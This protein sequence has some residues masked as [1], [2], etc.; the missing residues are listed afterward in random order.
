MTEK[1]DTNPDD[2]SIFRQEMA[3]VQRLRHDRVHHRGSRPPPRPLQTL[4]EQREV[5]RDMMSDYHD[6]AE[7]ETGEELSFAR[8]GVPRNTLRRLRRGQF[9]VEMELDLH[10]MTVA[11]ARE[12]LAHF[13]QEAREHHCGCLRVIHGKG[14]GSRGGQPIL[15]VKVNHWLRQRDEVLAFSTARAIDGGTGAIYVLVKR[16]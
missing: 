3:D 8:P 7:L 11:T 12:A 1:D 14:R 9:S 5:L 4:Q 15:K 2:I 10:G 13:L 6:P 16:R